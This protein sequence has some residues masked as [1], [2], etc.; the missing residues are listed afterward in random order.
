V[1][2]KKSRTSVPGVF[3]AGDC[4]DPIFKQAVSSAG[5]GCQTAIESER[6]IENLKATGKY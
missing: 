3:A 4:Q 5:S 1:T 2:D 6:Y